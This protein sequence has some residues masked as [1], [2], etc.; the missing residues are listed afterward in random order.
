MS[1]ELVECSRL[2]IGIMVGGRQTKGCRLF[3]RRS[4]PRSFRG[5]VGLGERDN[6]RDNQGSD[7]AILD[8]AHQVDV[9]DVTACRISRMRIGSS[10]R[11]FRR[12]GVAR[13]RL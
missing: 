9:G 6:R 10:S 12:D 3:G 8:D 11:R 1:Q 5:G 4:R 2:H 13:E 7:W